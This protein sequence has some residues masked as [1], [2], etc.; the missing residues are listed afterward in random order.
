LPII[1]GSVL[2]IATLFILINILVDIIYS[3]LDPRI[4]LQ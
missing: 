3:W 2:V 4:R 1:M